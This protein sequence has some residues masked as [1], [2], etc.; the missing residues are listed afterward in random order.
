MPDSDRRSGCPISI[1]LEIFG[2]RWSLLIIRDLMF[3]NRRSF[4]EFSAAG[5]NIASNVLTDRLERLE[6]AGIIA[7]RLDPADG[8]RAIY[9]L[10]DKGFDLAPMLIEMVIWAAKYEDTDAPPAVVKA[11]KRD[12]AGFIAGLRARAAS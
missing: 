1:S 8:R 6:T 7:R 4:R 12:R 5:E 10:T 9:S 11:M 3:E 2:D